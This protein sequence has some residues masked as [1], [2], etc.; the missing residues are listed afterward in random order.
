MVDYSFVKFLNADLDVEGDFAEKFHPQFLGHGPGAAVAR[1]GDHGDGHRPT[2]GEVPWADAQRRQTSVVV[3]RSLLDQARRV[4]RRLQR[5]LPCGCCFPV[6]ANLGHG[7]TCGVLVVGDD[8]IV[9]ACTEDVVWARC[10]H[11]DTIAGRA[12]LNAAGHDRLP[13]TVVAHVLPTID[14]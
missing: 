4:D 12:D 7:N 11:A 5:V 6:D 8:G 14:D 9:M 3:L 2:G 13:D 10:V 1:P